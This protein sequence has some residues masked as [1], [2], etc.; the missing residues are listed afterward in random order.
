MSR[1][2]RDTIVTLVALVLVGGIM[3]YYKWRSPSKLDVVAAVNRGFVVVEAR[4]INVGKMKV[5][6][7]S[8]RNMEIDILVGMVFLSQSVGTQDMMA[9]KSVHFDFEKAHLDAP[10]PSRKKSKFIVSTD[11]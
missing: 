10:S 4:G 1:G 8:T 7:T 5:T 11:S 6:I 3:A 9:S 2:T